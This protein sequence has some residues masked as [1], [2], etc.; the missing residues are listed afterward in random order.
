MKL[1]YI[2]PLLVIMVV[3]L[4][5]FFGCSNQP[6]GTVTCCECL[7]NKLYDSEIS[8]FGTVSKLGELLCSCF[9]LTSGGEEL[10]VFYDTMAEDDGTERP[11]VDIS[12]IKNGDSVVVNGELKTEGVHRAQYDF[13]A[14]TIEKR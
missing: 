5:S 9:I 2:V 3:V 11:A 10:V 12:G 6:E 14:A 7:E 4:S 13:W 1:K 8:V